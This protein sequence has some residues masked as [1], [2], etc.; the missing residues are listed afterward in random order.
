MWANNA[1]FGGKNRVFRR[2]Q[3]KAM[4]WVKSAFYSCYLYLPPESNNSA[5]YF[6][7]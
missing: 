4:K 2:S 6:E 7:P 5:V 1:F 3:L